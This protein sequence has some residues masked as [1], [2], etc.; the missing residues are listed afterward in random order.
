MTETTVYVYF[1]QQ[2]EG[3]KCRGPIK[4]GIADDVD[5]RLGELQV[6]NPRRLTIL[7][8]CPFPSRAEARAAE[9]DLHRRLAHL[10]IRGEWFHGKLYKL[11]RNRAVLAGPSLRTI[12]SSEA[13]PGAVPEIS[14]SA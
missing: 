12:K 1:I 7:F 10:N 14:A 8:R 11:I 4:I 3:Y 13:W 5:A 6:A 9:Q 2:W